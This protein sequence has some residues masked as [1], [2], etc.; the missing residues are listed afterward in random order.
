MT[1]IRS[2]LKKISDVLTGIDGLTVRHYT[3]TDMGGNPYCVWYEDA[4]G[5]AFN[6]DNTKESQTI[7]GVIDYFTKTEF[8]PQ[9]DAINLAL[10]G[11]KIPFR[12]D[13]VLYEEETDYIHYQWIFEAM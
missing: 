13:S 4:E 5:S 7:S 12:L 9:V 3:A 8:D 10:S 2:K 11:N 6:G 1:T